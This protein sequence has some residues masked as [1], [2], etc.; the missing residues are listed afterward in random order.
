VYSVGDEEEAKALISLCC[1]RDLAGTFYARE[2][3]HEQTLENL[4]KFSDKLHDGHARLVERGL[5]RCK[6]SHEEKAK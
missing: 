5:C 1:P 3:A 4:E 6:I 2:L